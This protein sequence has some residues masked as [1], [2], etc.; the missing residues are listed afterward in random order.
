MKSI[1]TKNVYR[2][3]F[4]KMKNNL[5]LKASFKTFGSNAHSHSENH[6][7]HDKSHSH[8]ESHDNHG[9]HESHDN[10]GH[11]GHDDH[12]GHHEITGEVDFEKIHVKNNKDVKSLF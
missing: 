10:H 2:F 12:H 5:L 3:P 1:V 8:H 7:S 6:N 4:L 9:H 11:H